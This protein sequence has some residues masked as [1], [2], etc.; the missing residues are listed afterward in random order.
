[1]LIQTHLFLNYWRKSEYLYRHCENL[2]LH[3][4]LGLNLRP[5]CKV[6]VA[7]K[8]PKICNFFLYLITTVIFVSFMVRSGVPL[9]RFFNFTTNNITR[10]SS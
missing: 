6:T 4:G 5:C 8:T 2:C 9:V 7:A 1:M 10:Y 3:K